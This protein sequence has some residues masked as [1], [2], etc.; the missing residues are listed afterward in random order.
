MKSAG[1]VGMSRRLTDMAIAGKSPFFFHRRYIFT[2][3][4]FS[5]VM[6]VFEGVLVFNLT[7]GSFDDKVAGVIPRENERISPKKGPFQEEIIIF[8]CHNCSRD[9]SFF[10]WGGNIWAHCYGYNS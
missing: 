2:H 10:L 6:L 4:C 7:R 3:G 8:Q 1:D 9:M 5:I